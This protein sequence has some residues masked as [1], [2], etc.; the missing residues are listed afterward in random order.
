MPDFRAYFSITRQKSAVRTLCTARI[1]NEV[2]GKL[3]R[4]DGCL[5]VIKQAL[6][7]FFIDV[8]AAFGQRSRLYQR[9]CTFGKIMVYCALFQI[10]IIRFEAAVVDDGQRFT[11]PSAPCMPSI[12]SHV[13][14]SEL[15]R[16]LQN[17]ISFY[18]AI[19]GSIS[20][21]P[22]GREIY[23]RRLLNTKYPTNAGDSAFANRSQSHSRSVCSTFHGN[24]C[25]LHILLE[26]AKE[27]YIGK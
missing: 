13:V 22:I 9:Y 26:A 3:S 27:R 18:F 14:A 12:E 10:V 4:K 8:G 16:S 17:R 19:E 5:K 1:F 25:Q 24:I 11:L 21:R 7:C 6:I 2:I 20:S 15:L 23:L